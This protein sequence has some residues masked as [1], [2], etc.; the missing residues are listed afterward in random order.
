MKI[1]PSGVV[2][3]G[4]CSI[5]TEKCQAKP[6]EGGA[7]TA[8]WTAPARNQVDVCGACMHEMVRLREWKV[9]GARVAAP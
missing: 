4:T 5:Q 1:E 2:F 7:L 9:T 3:W 8:V 6:P